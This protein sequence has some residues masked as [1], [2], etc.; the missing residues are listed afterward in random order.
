[1]YSHHN[2]SDSLAGDKNTQSGVY[3]FQKNRSHHL[4]LCAHENDEMIQASFWPWF[5]GEF[6]FKYSGP[7]FNSE[8]SG[9][10]F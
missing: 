9:T 1:M 3:I 6:F 2:G 8:R 10:F 7:V 4:F 5:P